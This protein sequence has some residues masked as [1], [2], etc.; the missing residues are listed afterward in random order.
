VDCVPSTNGVE[1][2]YAP[3]WNRTHPTWQRMITVAQSLGLTCGALWRTFPDA[4]HFQME[5]KFPANA[6]NDEVRQVFRDAG[7]IAVWAE[8]FDGQ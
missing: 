7:E 8:A 2:A 1:Q 5:G 4:P 6:P 3:D